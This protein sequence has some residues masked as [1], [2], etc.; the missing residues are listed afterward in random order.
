M[1][2]YYEGIVSADS[3]QDGSPVT[4]SLSLLR[5]SWLMG[6][7]SQLPLGKVQLLLL[8]SSIHNAMMM[9]SSWLLLEGVVVINAMYAMLLLAI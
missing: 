5:M 7:N 4:G 8:K 3:R 1:I 2:D 6:V 9:I